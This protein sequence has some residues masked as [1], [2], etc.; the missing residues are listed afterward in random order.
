MLAST[1]KTREEENLAE[2][3]AFGMRLVKSA[4]VY[5]ANASGKTKLVD[6]L[7]FMKKFVRNSSRETQLG[8]EIPVEPFRLSSLTDDAPS[9]FEVVF[10]HKKELYRYGF[11]VTREKVT[12]E[13]LFHRPKTKEVELFYR[14]GQNFELHPRK[15]SGIVNELVKNRNVREN[16]LL[17][18]VA[19]QFNNAIASSVLQWFDRVQILSGLSLAGYQGYSMQQAE[20]PAQRQEILELL[21]QA[22]FDI[23][24]L[25]V[26]TVDVSQ[27]P[28]SLPAELRA[29]ITEQTAEG[30]KPKIFADV[31]TSRRQYGP[32]NQGVANVQFSMQR[33]ESAGTQKFFALTGPLLDVIRRGL[34]LVVDELDSRLHP[35]LVCK[36]VA[37]F[38][39]AQHNSRNA[40]LLFNTQDTNLLSAGNLRRDQIW[41]AE[42]DK[43]GAASLFSLS[44]FKTDTVRK[45][46]N[47]ELNYIRGKYGAIPFL[48][49][50]QALP[51]SEALPEAASSATPDV[52]PEPAGKPTKRTPHEG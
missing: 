43:F 12:A 14:D 21:R 38:N 42:K 30:K 40:Q 29:M 51:T 22:D 45:A 37:L 23:D 48:G 20:K 16:A 6:A 36:I 15:F 10:L 4:V 47:F 52:A 13:W 8:D 35:N 18:S 5:G 46:D 41:F 27:L 19:A 24:D 44:D 34:V 31:L 26:Q 11:E 17:I 33:D 25:S 7:S 28:D 39:S 1:D 3:P 32:D 9:E 2:I 49:D 50:F